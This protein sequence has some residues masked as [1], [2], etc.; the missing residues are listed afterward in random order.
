MPSVADFT[1]IPKRKMREL[2]RNGK[3]RSIPRL[4]SIWRGPP[5]A[6][7]LSQ[8]IDGVICS[9]GEQSRNIARTDLH[10]DQW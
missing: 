4:Q 3:A 6:R 7:E 10:D 8:G 2:S 5:E 1:A 9:R